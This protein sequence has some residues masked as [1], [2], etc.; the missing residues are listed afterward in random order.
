MKR[1]LRDK[2]VPGGLRAAVDWLLHAPCMIVAG[3]SVGQSSHPVRAQGGRMQGR[4][5]SG[6]AKG[7]TIGLRACTYA[8]TLTRALSTPSPPISS[9]LEAPH[10]GAVGSEA[11]ILP[12]RARDLDD[13][14][15]EQQPVFYK[16]R[17]ITG[18]LRGAGTTEQMF[19]ELHGDF[20]SSGRLLVPTPLN[21]AT[22]V[23][24]MCRVHGELGRLQRMEVGFVD[25]ENATKNTG[26][27][28]LLDRIET[29][30]ID[31]SMRRI[32]KPVVFPCQR[33]I[34]TSESGSRSGMY[35]V[36]LPY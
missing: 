30:R 1:C 15:E 8:E 31:T 12:L 28:W 29:Y 18:D 22:T 3:S 36:Y 14:F 27:G 26:H 9:A 16:L 23:E 11:G 25:P 33:W 20:T 24:S 4:K 34:G 17:I 21:R 2:G 13:L 32:P 35:S 7:A 10:T 5:C 6:R 19:I